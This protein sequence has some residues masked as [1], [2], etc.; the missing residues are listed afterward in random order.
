VESK[1]T[2][3]EMTPCAWKF[4]EEDNGVVYNI[5]FNEV[6]WK[7]RK[8][9][10]EAMKD[11]QHWSIGWHKDS[12]NQLFSFKK[13]FKNQQEWEEW[14]SKFPM[15]I[16]EKRYWGDKEKVVIHGKKRK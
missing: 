14:A 10:L 16:V 8:V 9:L 6:P 15:Q 7:M 12:G 13:L 1:L 5:Q 2:E 3:S 11:W 4:V